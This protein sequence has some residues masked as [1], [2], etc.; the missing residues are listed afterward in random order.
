MPVSLVKTPPATMA[1]TGSA[2]IEG[3]RPF[4]TFES[5]ASLATSFVI[6]GF[7]ILDGGDRYVF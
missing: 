3:G 5:L 4:W 7:D 2:R 6:S 1:A